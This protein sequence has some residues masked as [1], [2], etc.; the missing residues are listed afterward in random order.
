MEAKIIRKYLSHLSDRLNDMD[1][2][3]IDSFCEENELSEDDIEELL[4]LRFIATKNGIELE[5]E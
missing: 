2:S 5:D 4:G 1:Y 3:E